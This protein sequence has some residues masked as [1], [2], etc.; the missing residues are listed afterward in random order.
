MKATLL[1]TLKQFLSISRLVL[2][3]MDQNVSLATPP[4]TVIPGQVCPKSTRNE[5]RFNLDAKRLFV[6]CSGVTE[7]CHMAITAHALQAVQVRLKSV[8][9][10][11]HFTFEAETV[12]RPYHPSHCC[13]VTEIYHMTLPAH[14]LCAVQDMLKSVSDEGHFTLE[15]ETVFR[16]YLLS[17]FGGVPQKC[18]MA[19]PAHALHAM[20]DRLKT[21]SNEGHFTL[22][23]Q[24]DICPYLPSHTVGSQKYATWHFLCMCYVQC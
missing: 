8:S 23:A 19:L 14:A 12:I 18:D 20:Q 5:V 1:L 13:G 24:T 11:G 16:P 10:E 22:E 15:A 4:D 7:I 17:H 6:Y 21:V 3:R 9:N 2:E